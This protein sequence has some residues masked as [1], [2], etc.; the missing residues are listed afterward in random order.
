MKILGLCASQRKLGNSEIL[1]K[2][3]LRF[4]PENFEK[5]LI[6]I[7]DLNIAPCKACYACLPEDKPCILNDDLNFL[8]T[9]IQEADIIL[10]ASPVYFLGIHN[11]LKVIQ[12][13]LLCVL[14]KGRLFIGKKA[15]LLIPYGINGWEGAA[16]SQLNTF[17]HCM[18]FDVYGSLVVQAANPGEAINQEVIQKLKKLASEVLSGKKQIPEK[19]KPLICP[20]CA[21]NLFQFFESGRV[22][23]VYCNLEGKIKMQENRITPEF[24]SSGLP[25][26]SLEGLKHHA[27]LLDKIKNDYIS[28]RVQ[29]NDIRKPYRNYDHLWIFPKKGN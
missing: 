13:R 24:Q 5:K 11:S 20:E 6:R 4:F 14:N 2:E 26:F 10:I 19:G 28:K 15:I 1:L 27:A 25:R 16:L 17:A 3:I 7:T 23:C 29:L 21:G 9:Q 8:L 22:L 12:D 18:H